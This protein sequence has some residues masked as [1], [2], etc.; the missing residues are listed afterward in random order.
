MIL[1]CPECATSYFVDDSRIPAAGR[2][3]KCTSCAARWRARPETAFA[4][5]PEPE[6]DEPEP[7]IAAAEDI[8]EA[9]EP[10]E[11]AAEPATAAAIPE[12]DLE[13]VEAEPAPRKRAAPARPEPKRQAIGA[14]IAWGAM[15]AT[16][17]ALV[18]G[19]I[20]FRKEVVRLAP[21]TS[22]AY[23][24]V[25]LPVNSLGL[26]IEHVKVEPTFQGGR[27][28]LSVTGSVRN[29]AEHA[30]DAPPLRIDLLDKAGEPVAA[31]IARPIDA[32]IPAGARR[33]FA[34]AIIDPPSTARDLQVAFDTGPKAE[35]TAHTAEAA[36]AAV[37][38]Q[39]IPSDS[40][41]ALPDH[42]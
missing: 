19:A 29:V 36:P 28:V 8:V 2:M 39:P 24:G 34:I 5:E 17:A 14:V 22:G 11:V 4:A 35:P 21:Q 10:E 12:D 25:G 1:T 37:E 26:V 6:F 9:A 33:H 38:A 20:V 40:P 15:A 23:A 18:A 7:Q 16:V 32:R 31:K 30:A 41:H 27:P 3:V 13:F 42:G